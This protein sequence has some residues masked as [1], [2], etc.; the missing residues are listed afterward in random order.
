RPRRE[1]RGHR[2]RR[3]RVGEGRR[4]SRRPI[5]GRSD[6]HRVTPRLRHEV[7]ERADLRGHV[8][9]SRVHDVER[10]RLDAPA[11]EHLYDAALPE[12]VFEGPQRAEMDAMSGLDERAD[13]RDAVVT[14]NTIAPGPIDTAFYHSQENAQSVE[15]VKRM[16]PAGRL[17][18][19]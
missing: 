4:A 12:R 17:G 9:R 16:S 13:A 6:S 15:Y 8:G 7:G 5:S 11:E 18:T 2:S 10:I 14:V 1:H 19:P 3:P